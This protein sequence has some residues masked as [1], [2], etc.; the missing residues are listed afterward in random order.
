MKKRFLHSVNILLG[1][2]SMALAGCHTKQVAV[3]EQ[4]SAPRPMLKYG[5]PSEV[6]AMYGVP[7]PVVEQDTVPAPK[8][9]DTRVV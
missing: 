4:E 5:V 3:A 6:R 9:P 1:I 7:S 8:D 2:A